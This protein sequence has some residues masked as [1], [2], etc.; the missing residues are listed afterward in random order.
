MTIKECIDAVDSLK[1]NQYTLR[2][3]VQW[4]SSVDEGIINDVLKTHEGYDGR[5][6]DFTGYTEDNLALPLIVQSPYDRLYTAFLEM[7]IDL[8][9][10]EMPR[11]NNSASVYNSYM[12]EYRKYYN[13]TH[14]PLNP[15]ERGKARPPVKSQIGLSEAEFENL[16]RVLFHMLSE[17]F[18]DMTSR[19]KLYDIVTN[20]ALNNIALLK[21]RDGTVEFANLTDEQKESLRGEAFSFEDFTPEQL[22]SLKV[23][24]DRGISGVYVG[25]GDM[26]E[27]CNV[28]IDPDGEVFEVYS[29]AE[30]DEMIGNIEELLRGI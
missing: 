27:D 2:D 13:K 11:Y 8:E 24:G 26:P 23:K 15:E 6:D 29:M 12:M 1:P 17:V 30:I 10:R 9:N 7:K 21:G 25:S 16:K 5:Y 20:F 4:L 22:E 28:Q 19:D 3:K 18:A 14:M